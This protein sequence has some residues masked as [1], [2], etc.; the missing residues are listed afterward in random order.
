[1]VYRTGELASDAAVEFNDRSVELDEH[2]LKIY[3][4]RVPLETRP[5]CM[6]HR[7]VITGSFV[8]VRDYALKWF[9]HCVH[10]KSNPLDNV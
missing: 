7:H 4:Y 6:S 2:L 10:E 3:K 1:M 8:A 5:S 9:L